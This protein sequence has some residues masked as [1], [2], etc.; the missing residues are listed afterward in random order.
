M[1]SRF[2]L[3]EAAPAAP[4]RRRWAWWLAGL[5]LPLLLLGLWGSRAFWDALSPITKKAALYRLAG[6]TKVDPLLLAAIVRAES[7]FNPIAESSRGA[8]GLMQLM[9]STARQVAGKLAL[10]YQDRDDLYAQ[11]INL[12]LGAHYFAEQLKAFRGDLVLALA[13]YNAGPAKVRSWKLD[14]WGR[15]Q[16]ELIAEV[17]I[18]ATRSYVRRVLW[19]YRMFKRLQAVKRF[20][21]ADA[22]P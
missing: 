5:G 3:A 9:P 11:D 15:D 12:S 8:V 16:E 14:P 4:R 13:A 22:T 10:N 18:P 1:L 17:P 21:N 6:E 2:E 7:G 20:L 19:H